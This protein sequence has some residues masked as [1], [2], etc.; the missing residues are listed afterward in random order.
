MKRIAFTLTKLILLLSFFHMDAAMSQVVITPIPTLPTFPTFT[1]SIS[2]TVSLDQGVAIKDYSVRVEVRRYRLE[3]STYPYL[4]SRYVTD[5]LYTRT[6]IIRR[7]SASVAYAVGGISTIGFQ[8]YGIKFVCDDCGPVISEQYLSPA[9]NQFS[10]NRTVVYG[11]DEFPTRQNFTLSTGNS[12]KGTIR[13]PDGIV[14]PRD[15]E[16][17][18]IGTFT[19][20]PNVTF[21]SGSIVIANGGSSFNYEIGG[22]NPDLGGGATLALICSNCQKFSNARYSHPRVLAFGRNH[23]GVDFQLFD[24]SKAIMAAISLLLGD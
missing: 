6:V 11:G 9:G 24:G 18:I 20:N 4:S 12:I 17:Q 23:T 7:G 22:F 16:F 14:A 19:A 15:L 1:R 2:G 3:F 21:R 13:L 10:F 8:N 5:D